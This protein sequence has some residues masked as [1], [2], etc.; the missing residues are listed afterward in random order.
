MTVA[1]FYAEVLAMLAAVMI[2]WIVNMPVE[3]VPYFPIIRLVLEY[4]AST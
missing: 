2:I 1:F 4:W 3:T